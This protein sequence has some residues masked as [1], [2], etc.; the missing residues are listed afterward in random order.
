MGRERWKVLTFPKDSVAKTPAPASNLDIN[1]SSCPSQPALDEDRL[2]TVLQ[3]IVYYGEIE[4]SWHSAQ[5]RAGRNITQDDIATMLQGDWSL[6]GQPDWEEAH[7]KW[8][9]K[10]VGVDLEG[11]ALVLKTAVNEEMQRVTVI[12]KY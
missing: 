2:R 12:T 11:D 8:E 6:A 3:R 4:E 7:R 9:Y 5:D 1:A 10:V